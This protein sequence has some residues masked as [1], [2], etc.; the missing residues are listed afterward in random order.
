LTTLQIF[1]SAF[2]DFCSQQGYGELASECETFI[3]NK[4]M[5][6]DPE[7]DRFKVW[8]TQADRT[9]YM[10]VI[11]ASSHTE[12]VKIYPLIRRKYARH[13]DPRPRMVEAYLFFYSQLTT[14]FI[15]AASE[16]PICADKPLSARLDQAFQALR[17]YLLVVII[18]L[19]QG[20]DAQVIFET[21]NARGEP[22]LPADLLRNYIF[23]RAAREGVPSE[24]LYNQYWAKFD[25]PFWR[26]HVS[27]GRLL[28]PRSDLFMQHFLASRQT[29]DIPIKHLY[30]EY[31]VWI[32]KKRPFKTVG[33]E[34]AVLSKQGDDFHRIL[35][36]KHDDPIHRLVSFLDAFDVSMCAQYTRYF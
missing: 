16:P 4:G 5:M 14:F 17:N 27:Q 31:K 22:L 15:G 33:E 18:D 28:R 7:V 34:L 6:A 35:Q 13:P 2:R 3:L 19:E 32:E 25:D 21:L 23:L 1:L 29:I 26:E 10:N 12:L 11:T 24:A 36:P 9:V 8:P 20:D 30:A